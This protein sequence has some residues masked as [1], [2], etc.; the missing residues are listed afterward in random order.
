M[1]TEHLYIGPHR[2]AQNVA[3][4]PQCLSDTAFSVDIKGTVGEV[5]AAGQQ[6]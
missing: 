2:T 1:A 3:S 6:E 4:S 5:T